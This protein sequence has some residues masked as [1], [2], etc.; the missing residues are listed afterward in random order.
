M[1]A[2]QLDAGDLGRDEQPTQK[3]KVEKAPQE[4]RQLSFHDGKASHRREGFAKD[5][6]E[7]C[8][9]LEV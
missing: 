1:A 5:A 7:V 9:M 6:A 2:W 3:D 4:R 8:K